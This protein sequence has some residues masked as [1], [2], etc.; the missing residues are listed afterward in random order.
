VLHELEGERIAAGRVLADLQRGRAAT[1]AY[2]DVVLGA[3]SLSDQQQTAVLLPCAERRPQAGSDFLV[4][5]LLDLEPILVGDFREDE[6]VVVVG[7]FAQACA[8]QDH[9]VRAAF[10]QHHEHRFIPGADAA[11]RPQLAK[12]RHGSHRSFVALG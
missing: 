6:L 11:E 4:Q 7:Q 1:F 5:A 9:Q 8:L 2:S 10:R 3:A 12:S